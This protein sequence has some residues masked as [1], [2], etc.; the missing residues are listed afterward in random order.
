MVLK[1]HGLKTCKDCVKYIFCP[2]RSRL[3]PCRDFDDMYSPGK[4]NKKSKK[5]ETDGK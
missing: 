5:G 4:D 1:N 3:Y 2:D